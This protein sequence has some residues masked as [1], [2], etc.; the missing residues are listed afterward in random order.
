MLQEKSPNLFVYFSDA[1]TNQK[2]FRQKT[3]SDIFLFT[4]D[5]NYCQKMKH[6]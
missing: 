6:R 5:V 3:E 1:K 4:S 2:M